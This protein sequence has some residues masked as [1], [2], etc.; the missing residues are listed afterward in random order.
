MKYKEK[1]AIAAL[2]QLRPFMTKF[3]LEPWP[4]PWPRNYLEDED[5]FY[6][7]VRIGSPSYIL[8]EPW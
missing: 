6:F 4:K 7:D 5:N 3:N 1:V 2:T 8:Y